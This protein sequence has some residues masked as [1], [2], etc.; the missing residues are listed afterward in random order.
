V[1]FCYTMFEYMW[2]RRFNFSTVE[3]RRDVVSVVMNLRVLVPQ[4]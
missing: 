2:L 3:S 1:F 4:S